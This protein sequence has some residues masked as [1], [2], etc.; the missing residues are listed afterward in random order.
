VTIVAYILVVDDEQDIAEV[1][2]ITLETRG[3]DV[4][5][6]ENGVKALAMIKKKEPDLVVLDVMMPKMNGM[7]VVDVMRNKE[8]LNH[9]PII[10]LTAV[11]KDSVQ[12]DEHWKKKVGVEDFMSKPFEPLE[13][14]QRVEDLLKSHY[15]KKFDDMGR[16]RIR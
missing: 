3:H 5:T 4:R 13:L 14:L 2:K 8:S 9:I 10:M 16:Y 15:R 1:L 11:T 6:A 7:Q 12:P